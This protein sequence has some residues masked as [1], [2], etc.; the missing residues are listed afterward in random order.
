MHSDGRAFTA[1]VIAGPTVLRWRCF[2]ED[3]RDGIGG[4]QASRSSR[5]ARRLGVSIRTYREIE[6]GAR[7]PTRF[8]M[9]FTTRVVGDVGEKGGLHA[10]RSRLDEMG[11][12]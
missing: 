4:V 7:S 8:G 10:I 12:H 1:L 3:A 2:P 6:A 5:G 9:T 11:G